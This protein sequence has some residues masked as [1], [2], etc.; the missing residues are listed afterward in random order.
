[1]RPE[2]RGVY[3]LFRMGLKS[4]SSSSF[5][6]VMINGAPALMASSRRLRKALSANDVSTRGAPACRLF[7][8][9]RPCSWGS[10][11]RGNLGE[12]ATTIAFSTLTLSSGSPSLAHVEMVDSST[13][14]VRTLSSGVTNAEMG[15]MGRPLATQSA[16]TSRSSAVRNGEVNGPA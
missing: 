2:P 1:M 15:E 3:S 6:S 10:M 4:E 12:C 9:L 7:S 5:A 11:S 13:Q 14:K 16:W 8:Q